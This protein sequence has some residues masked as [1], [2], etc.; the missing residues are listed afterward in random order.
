MKLPNQRIEKAVGS[1]PFTFINDGLGYGPE[2]GRL[3]A[4]DGHIIVLVP[5]VAEP[6]EVSGYIP[7][8]AVKKMRAQGSKHPG[9][10]KAYKSCL[11]RSEDGST[12]TTIRRS[13]RKL[14]DVDCVTK[15]AG[16]TGVPDF[17]LDANLLILL[18]ETM[19]VGKMPAALNFYID[20]THKPE[21]GKALLVS[22]D[23]SDG[24]VALIMPMRSQKKETTAESAMARVSLPFH[25][26][27]KAPK[28]EPEA[29]E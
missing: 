18:A 8:A 4:T 12:I 15:D 29:A 3:F 21:E 20:H 14:P 13:T 28:P 17:T 6:K 19:R 2:K 23:E 11:L 22:T 10:L 1:D 25:N 27:T 24:P 26:S 16:Y 7:V 5:S 9:T